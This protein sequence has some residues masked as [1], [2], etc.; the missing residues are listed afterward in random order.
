MKEIRKHK[1]K[2][3]WYYIRLSD[4][5]LPSLTKMERLKRSYRVLINRPGVI[6]DIKRA[7]EDI[8]HG[9]VHRWEDVQAEFRS[10]ME[11]QRKS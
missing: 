4:S 11:R 7:D 8:K 10:R 5:F 1:G 9:R 3:N 6:E 2:P